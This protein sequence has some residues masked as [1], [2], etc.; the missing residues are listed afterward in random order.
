MKNIKGCFKIE[1]SLVWRAKK[2][3]KWDRQICQRSQLA[4]FTLRVEYLYTVYISTVGDVCVFSWRFSQLALERILF[5]VVSMQE[6]CEG[7][8]RASRLSF[9]ISLT[10]SRQSIK[11]REIFLHSRVAVFLAINCSNAPHSISNLSPCHSERVSQSVSR[12][13]VNNCY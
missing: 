5:V 2:C 4:I 6:V 11:P 3:L 1:R 10:L 9:S 7:S 12:S 13:L 8:K